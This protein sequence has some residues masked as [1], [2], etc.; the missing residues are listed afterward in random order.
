[1]LELVEQIASLSDERALEA[2]NLL[3][4]EALGATPDDEVRSQVASEIGTEPQT[5]Q[6]ALDQE[7]ADHV[8]AL[9]RVVLIAHAVYRSPNEVEEAINQTGKKAF[10]LEAAII[11]LIG[12]GILHLVLTKGRKSKTE[13]TQMAV[14]P[15]GRVTV[16]IDRKTTY[17]SVGEA[18]APFLSTILSDLGAT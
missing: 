6:Q 10:L 16:T 9:A 13:T 3:G 17:Y 15:S 18:L 4:G 7:R 12:F 11:G 8:A 14:D 1:M 5:L 2:V